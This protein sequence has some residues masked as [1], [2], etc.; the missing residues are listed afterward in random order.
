MCAVFQD[1]S[2]KTGV[3]ILGFVRETCAICL[4]I[5]LFQYKIDVWRYIL[6]DPDF[7]QS[8]VEHSCPKL[9]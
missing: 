8:I 1:E 9:L 4:V 3:H 6:V 2:R 7:R 5:T